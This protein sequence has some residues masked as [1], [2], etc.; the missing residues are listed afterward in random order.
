M[1]G[2]KNTLELLD[3]VF[4]LLPLVRRTDVED[5]LSNARDMAVDAVARYHR[6]N[7]LWSAGKN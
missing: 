3:V 4:R 2:G 6:T 5:D 1:F 7:A